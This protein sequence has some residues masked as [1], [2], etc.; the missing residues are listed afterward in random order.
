MGALR[1]VFGGTFD[2]VHNGHL[3]VAREAVRHFHAD[4]HLLPAADPPHR[5]PPR[6]DAAQ[7]VAMLELALR[8]E[9][10]LHLDTRELRRAG[11]SYSVD[12]LL[13]LRRELGPNAPLA[14]LVG[15][16]AFAGL[17]RWHRWR[18]LLGLAH[19]IIAQ[20]PD[21]KGQVREHVADIEATWPA[22]LRAHA[23]GHWV[24]DP[25]QLHQT[26][27]GHLA[28][29]Q[30]PPRPESATGVRERIAGGGDWQQWVPSAVAAHIRRHG[31][32]GVA[33]DRQ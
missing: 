32:Y 8:G 9:P 4:V 26:P 5:P 31:L 20:R 1:I 19:W 22:E 7:R 11:P 25:G 12:S 28:R 27:S 23:G 2:P 16:D 24:E 14:W 15:E 10:R 17:S 6:V 29:L 21:T 33:A 18:E 13:E 3:A 30:L